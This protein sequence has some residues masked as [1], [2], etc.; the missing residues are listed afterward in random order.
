VVAARPKSSRFSKWGSLP[1]A[2]VFNKGVVE[3]VKTV[4]G[5]KPLALM[6]ALV[7]DYTVRGDLVCDPCAG[8]ATTLI[9]A[10][11]L[12][13]RGVGAESDPETYAKAQRR[14]SRGVQMDLLEATR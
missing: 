11:G 9:A 14:I 2:Y 10:G 5:G 8:G 7:R 3:Q 1:G 4:T 13:R 12:G 6:N